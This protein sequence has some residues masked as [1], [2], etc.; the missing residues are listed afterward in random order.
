[1]NATAA[2]SH[3]LNA[4][5]LADTLQLTR[6]IYA[7]IRGRIIRHPPLL[8]QLAAALQPGNTPRGPERRQQPRSRPPLRTDA[9]DTLTDIYV[10]ITRWH[11]H[12][13]LP[14]PARDN[15]WFKTALHQLADTAPHLAPS[16]ADQLS[17]DVHQWWRRAATATGWRPEQLVRLR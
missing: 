16:I 2:P 3:D 17:N 11:T 1:M 12:L 15:D 4:R 13:H 10:H 14:R 8:D 6:P 5:L 7:V 9:L